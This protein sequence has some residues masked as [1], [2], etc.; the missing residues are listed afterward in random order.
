[1]AADGA[2]EEA[3]VAVTEA[4]LAQ[5][6]E[7]ASVAI[8]SKGRSSN[9]TVAADSEPVAGGSAAVPSRRPGTEVGAGIAEAAASVAVTEAALADPRHWQWGNTDSSSNT[10]VADS[11]HR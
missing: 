8:G 1:M 11:E 3:S 4:A 10:A 7:A 6:S 2:V 5:A 9:N